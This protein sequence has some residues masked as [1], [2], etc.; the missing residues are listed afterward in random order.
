[1]RIAMLA[2][3]GLVT[4]LPLAAQ[5]ADPVID[6]AR[7]LM[8]S[9]QAEK[10][11]DVLEK[12]V[13]AKPKDAVRH[14]W[15]ANAYGAVAQ[16]SGMFR[17]MSLA[18]KAG[19]EFET[20]VTLDPNYIDARLGVLEFN[21][22]VPGVMGGDIDKAREQAAEIRK[23]DAMLGHRAFAEIA[24]TKKDANTVRAEYAAAARENPNSPKPHYW[25]GI[26]LMLN[27]KNYQGASAEFDAAL[28]VDAG[29]MPAHFQIG[30]LA[31]LS[32][33]NVVRGEQALQKYL[34]H[35]PAGD[36]P[37][38]YRAHY[39]LGV[40][41]EKQGKNAEARGHFQEALRLHPE[42]KDAKQ[43]LKRVS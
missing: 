22:M 24:A 23:R 4:T 25:Y 21:L 38:L 1:M 36:D 40:I 12:A 43:G 8:N 14:F 2:L 39:W 6:Q 9:A 13:A 26:Y 17:M 30:H 37:P 42:D 27:E 11:V 32:G 35:R 10:A 33:L 15:L 5:S 16:N 29:Y 3:L 31:G 7:S 18:H 20:A 41:D 34:A 19:T 28:H